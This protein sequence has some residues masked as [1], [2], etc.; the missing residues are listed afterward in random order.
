MRLRC[1]AIRAVAFAVL[2]FVSK[3]PDLVREL[4]RRSYSEQDLGKPLG[5]NVLRVM[6]QVEQVA[7]RTPAAY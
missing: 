2:V 3:L 7:R 6:Q 4:A 5:G 1:W